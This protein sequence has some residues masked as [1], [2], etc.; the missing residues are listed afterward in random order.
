MH[1]CSMIL[2]SRCHDMK[3]PSAIYIFVNLLG[4]MSRISV[5]SIIFEVNL[6]LL[7][8]YIPSTCIHTV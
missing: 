1:L 7:Y 8:L 5:K 6:T 2:S 4:S 3:I